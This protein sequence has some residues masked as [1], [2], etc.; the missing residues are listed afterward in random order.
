MLILG[1]KLISSVNF[2]VTGHHLTQIISEFTYFAHIVFRITVMTHLGSQDQF[3]K[4][5]AD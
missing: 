2:T 3:D 1:S 5:G 4:V